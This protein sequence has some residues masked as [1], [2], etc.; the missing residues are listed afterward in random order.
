M[1]LGEETRVSLQTGPYCRENVFFPVAT[2]KKREGEVKFGLRQLVHKFHPNNSSQDL[3]SRM[4]LSLYICNGHTT[5]SC[6]N[7]SAW[8]G[9]G[10]LPP[11]EVP[12]SGFSYMKGYGFHLL[13]YMK[14]SAL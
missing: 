7:S 2:L 5:N 9:E 1:N 14:V 3:I 11:K 13:K 6:Q 8:G 10:R 12:F 4:A